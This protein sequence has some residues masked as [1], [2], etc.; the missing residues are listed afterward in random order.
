MRNQ[1]TILYIN[2]GSDAGD[3]LAAVLGGAGRSIRMVD[4]V[5]AAIEP[6]QAGTVDAVVLALDAPA[7]EELGFL[8]AVEG[9]RP[10]LPVIVLAGEGAVSSAGELI[11]ARAYDYL[12][13]PVSPEVLEETLWQALSRSAPKPSE[14]SSLS[15]TFPGHA[16]NKPLGIGASWREVEKAVA[17]AAAAGEAVLILGET[18]T[19]KEAVARMLHGSSAR[20]KG[21]FIRLNCADLSMDA[22]EAGFTTHRR[23]LRAGASATEFEGVF[24][25]ARTGSL[26]LDEV[27]SL[28]E[29]AQT[30]ILRM[31]HGGMNESDGIHA[32]LSADVRLVASCSIDLEAAVAA[33]NF[34]R[35][36]FNE[37][38]K[39][40]IIVPPL[41][42]RAE[43]VGFL[44][45]IFLEEYATAFRK[46][47]RAFHPDTLARLQ[48]YRWPGNV[49]ELRNV[50]ERA[51]LLAEAEE[52][53][54]SCLPFDTAGDSSAAGS[55]DLN[56]RT[57]LAEEEKRTLIEALHR[58][59]G[60][61]R[62]AARLLGIDPR[63]LVYFLRKYG[64]EKRE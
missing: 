34:R 45:G 57:V 7:E 19:G 29:A 52:I 49:R 59:Q 64:L 30:D 53:P 56:L 21:P 27:N 26:F 11:R 2:G 1:G 50:V 16:F 5:E 10:G 42:D 32:P 62:E 58:A 8:R 14:E 22:F 46:P 44:A 9:V 25:R 38:N 43:D 36:L 48:S 51:V 33:G 37:L 17:R 18:G 61:R 35:D 24:Q 4:S 47:A 20:E 63:N 23:G 41:R 15:A 3:S 28:S 54:P 6:L 31:L 60:V 13:K 39:M 55:R 40:V 12:V